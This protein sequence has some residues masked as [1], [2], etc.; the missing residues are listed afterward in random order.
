MRYD[1]PGTAELRY[2]KSQNPLGTILTYWGRAVVGK[3]SLAVERKLVAK[4]CL[5]AEQPGPD[6]AMF[7][8]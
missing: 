5:L 8:V 6:P 3:K 7:V 4:A 2:A 1:T